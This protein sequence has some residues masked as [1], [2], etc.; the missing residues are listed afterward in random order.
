MA[1]QMAQDPSFQAMTQQL[2]GMGL[3]GMVPPGAPAGEGAAATDPA[4]ASRAVDA[5]E[6]EAAAAAGVPPGMPNVNPEQYMKVRI[7]LTCIARSAHPQQFHTSPRTYHTVS[8]T[9][10]IV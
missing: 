9:D 4:T 1:E 7:H 8:Y 6:G 2:A 3:G 5:P 10:M